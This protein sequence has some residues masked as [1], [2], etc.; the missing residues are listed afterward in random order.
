MESKIKSI[1]ELKN[2]YKAFPGVIALSDVSMEIKEGE[3]FG[4]V[5][6]N[7]AGK[8]TLVKILAGVYRKDRGKIIIKGEECSITSMSDAQSRGLSF[9]FQE[10]NL[11]PFLSVEENL[12]AGRQPSGA[13]GFIKWKELRKTAS[14]ILDLL[15][16]ELDP[17]DIVERLSTAEQQIVEIGRALSF[18]S[19]VIVMD[20]PTASI[21]DEEASTLFKVIRNLKAKGVTII[22]ISHRLKEVLEITDRV[23]IMRDGKVIKVCETSKQTS[24]SLIKLMV[25]R[26]LKNI[27][28]V[29]RG[30]PGD[31]VILSVR[32]LSCPGNFRD[33]TFDLK[34]GEI[35][36]FAGLVGAGRTAVL[37]AI[38]GFQKN[39]QGEIYIQGN[40]ARY[41]DPIGALRM[42]ISY[43]SED[44]IG[45][46][47]FPFLSVENNISIST[48]EKFVKLGFVISKSERKACTEM[49][50][51]LKIKSPDLS[52]LIMYLSG[53]NQQ[54]TIIARGFLCN[55][56]IFL[57]DEPTAGIDVGAKF[58]IYNILKNLASRGV[59]ILFVSSELTELL[60]ICHR[61][62]VMC[63]GRITGVFNA[64][65][66]DQEAIM[67]KATAFT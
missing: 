51:A 59:G 42:G 63:Q 23:A 8:S 32:K 29:K 10:R 30:V 36:G 54:K 40:K 1:I 7:G 15:R 34:K 2:I 31:E 17:G 41:T 14:E 33:I 52:T 11:A 45:E 46:G 25:G 37:R 18:N 9:I 67:E 60:G 39:V 57:L 50:A 64:E 16:C 47:I 5:G 53:G 22:F 58:E 19:K 20:E 66:V 24:D 26:N 49:A 4:I 56:K 55:P 28:E 61:I 13:F 12:F 21:S 35:L 44:R 48:L 38:F 27:F 3:V 62:I 43:L 6:E 65:D